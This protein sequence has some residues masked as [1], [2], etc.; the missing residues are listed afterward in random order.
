MEA[1]PILESVWA[2]MYFQEMNFANTWF[3]GRLDL[4]H[5]KL[6]RHEKT[7]GWVSS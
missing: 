7:K 5:C 2:D 4:V 6:N 1:D 3:Q